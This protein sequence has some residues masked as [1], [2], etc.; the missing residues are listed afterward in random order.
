MHAPFRTRAAYPKGTPGTKRQLVGAADQGAVRY[1]HY[2]AAIGLDI[3]SAGNLHSISL[4][5]AK[6]GLRVTF[7]HHEYGG[8]PRYRDHRLQPEAASHPRR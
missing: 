6:E 7:C 2:I 1:C 4:F 3:L 5:T 8:Y